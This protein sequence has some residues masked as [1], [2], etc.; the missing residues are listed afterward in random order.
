MG[1]Y[2]QPTRNHLPVERFVTPAEFV[3]YRELG[4]ERGFLEVVA[5]PMVRSSYRADRV[6]EKNNAGISAGL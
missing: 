6:L 2:L 3:R 1:Q 5:G 4:L